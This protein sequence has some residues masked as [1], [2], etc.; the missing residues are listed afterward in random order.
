MIA[1][2]IDEVQHI[3]KHLCAQVSLSNEWQ[4][5]GKMTCLM[6]DKMPGAWRHGA[7]MRCFGENQNNPKLGVANRQ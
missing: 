3:A 7:R 4:H 5:K 2:S 6:Y 1:Y